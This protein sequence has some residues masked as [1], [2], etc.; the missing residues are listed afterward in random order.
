MTATAPV[1][2]LGVNEM[3]L[4]AARTLRGRH[5]IRVI[6]VH[7]GDELVA[8]AAY[9]RHLEL[10][11]GPDIEDESALLDF[12]ERLAAELQGGVVL[13]P[14]QDAAVLF[15]HRHRARLL[16][17]FRF[18]L[19]DSDVLAKLGS[20][21]GLAAVASRYSL[22]A[23]K[24]IAPASGTELE[25]AIEHLEFPVL[26]KPEF[27]VQWWTDEAV[28]LGLGHKAITVNDAAELRSVYERSARV[29]TRV[30][31]QSI[32][33]GRDSDH[34]S[35]GAWVGQNGE[36]NAEI[37]VRKLRINPP[38]RGIG[39]YVVTAEDSEM[40]RAGREILRKLGFRGFASVQLKRDGD[41]GAPTLIEINLR[42]P[43]WVDLAIMAGVDF[44]YLYYQTCIGA[45][46]PRSTARVGCAWMSTGRDWR[47]MRAYARSGEWT[48]PQWLSQCL[49]RPTRAL[50]RLSDPL[51]AMVAAWR[52]L[53]GSFGRRVHANY[54]TQADET[55]TVNESR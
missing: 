46:C 26:V 49:A 52:W 32:I 20:K 21:R 51:P 9:S 45:A 40:L 8:P 17:R 23:P 28:A 12:L 55:R 2:I 35:Y 50:F 34:W 53:R 47:S 37:L 11:R 7:C 15:L 42:L 48:W 10:E 13:L 30:V 24:T 54:S 19:W 31:I 44:P 16:R 6:A 18:F 4:A 1:V 14:V 22:P 29:G 33:R 39:S 36:T 25:D 5:G 27:T 38:V 3:A 41:A 43:T